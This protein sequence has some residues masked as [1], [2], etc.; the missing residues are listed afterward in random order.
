MN[1]RKKIPAIAH[2][3]R[4]CRVTIESMCQGRGKVVSLP[5]RCT[6]EAQVKEGMEGLK[7]GKTHYLARPVMALEVGMVGK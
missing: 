1:L 2:V 3:V 7:L 6:L 5:N 4:I